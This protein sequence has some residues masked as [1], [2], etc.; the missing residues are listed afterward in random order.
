MTRSRRRTA[1]LAVRRRR[2]GRLHRRRHRRRRRR[3]PGEGQV[4]GHVRPPGLLQG[5]RCLTAPYWIW[6]PE[7]AR[8]AEQVKAKTYKAGYEYFDADS[9]AM[10][11]HGLH[12]RRD[13]DEGRRR[14]ARA[15]TSRWSRTR[16]P[17]CWPATSAGS[18][19]SPGRSTTTPARSSCRPARSSSSPTSTSSRP[20]R[21]APS[22]RPACTGGTR[23]SRASCRP[24]P[25]ARPSAV[26]RPAGVRVR[27]AADAAD[28]MTPRCAATADADRR[29]R[30]SRRAG[31]SSAFPGVLA[32]DHVDF[33]LRTG[34]V[35]A[36][37]GENGAG[38][39][40]LMNILAGLYR[41]DEGEILARRQA[42]RV[43]LAARRDRGRARAWSTSTSR[44]SRRRR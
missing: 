23:A 18:T 19:S 37:L 17:R 27:P 32:N 38:K 22:A 2:P 5:R 6:G 3:R 36:L 13:P 31:S 35:H 20:A 29:R 16:W 12:G 7:Y 44:W 42:G 30:R 9:K 11:L 1:R 41:P 25:V 33:E 24:W 10:G 21:P 4:G 14:P 43:R 15:R 28:R 39:S 40:T 8:I 26:P 34:E